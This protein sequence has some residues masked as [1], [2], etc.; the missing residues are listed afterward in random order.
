M[1][2]HVHIR[3]PIYRHAII[4]MCVHLGQCMFFKF[5]CYV[6]ACTHKL[7]KIITSR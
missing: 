7:I 3:M 4:C 2:N 1:R 6:K 5:A